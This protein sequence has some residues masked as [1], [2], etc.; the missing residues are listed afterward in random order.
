MYLHPPWYQCN[1]RFWRVKWIQR[2]AHRPETRRWSI[3]ATVLHKHLESSSAAGAEI[4]ARGFETVIPLSDLKCFRSWLA[5]C[6]RVG[7]FKP[8]LT[9]APGP[10]FRANFDYLVS[11]PRE[12]RWETTSGAALPPRPPP[13]P[14]PTTTTIDAVFHVLIPVYLIECWRWSAGSPGD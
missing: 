14:P 8:G 6:L 10:I 4:G 3:S 9:L 7:L 11:Q 2:F 13:L 1:W 12:A 5:A